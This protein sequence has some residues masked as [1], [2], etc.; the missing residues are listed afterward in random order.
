MN[1]GLVSLGCSKNQVD[2]EMIL[3][4]F[5][6]FNIDITNDVEEADIIVV[7]TCGF[8]E[9]AKKEAIDTILEMADYKVYGIC[10]ALIVTGC[11]AKRYK[12]QII[13]TMPEVDLCIG[14]DEYD[15]IGQILSEFLNQNIL[16]QHL[17]F[18]DR[19]IS[20][21]FPLAYIRISDGCDNRC[22]YCAIPLIRGNHKSRKIE[23]IVFEVTNLAKQGI[24]E[25]CL[26][27]QD[28]SKYGLDIYGNLKLKE[29]ISKI[30]KI[31]GVKWV[32]ILYMYLFETTDE[33][34]EEIAN[35]P[36]VCKYFDI[37][38]QH[39]SNKM[40]KDM[41]RHDTKGLIYERVNKIREMVP[42]AILRTTV[43]TGFPGE[44]EEDFK[45]LEKGIKDL[46]FDRLGAFAYSREED[47]PSFNMPH[48][49]R[50][51]TK[52][53][54][55]SEIMKQQSLIS[56]DLNKK[57]VGEIMNGIIT[58][59]LKEN[60]YTVRTYFNAP[61]DIDGNI[62]IRSNI[63]LKEGDIVKIKINSSSF[64]DLSGELL[65][66]IEN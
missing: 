10:K 24:K 66:I 42:D 7:N 39:I 3:G 36:K 64:Y 62:Y 6:K 9:S 27:A 35:N 41:N 16:N 34:I 43:I 51:K 2:S 23:D 32:R 19:V 55:K 57:H 56:Y 18:N 30:T 38:I 50:E 54:R 25:F 26:I 4:L 58:Y 60:E 29:L 22:S 14:V 5:K 8:I 49:V 47:T 1:V 63:P 21:N 40:L 33:L 44:T 59:K 45:E 12:K 37:P 46:K 20:T 28:T 65:E 61:D 13:K 52:E 11:L 17:D 15:N 48:Q 31:E 53:L